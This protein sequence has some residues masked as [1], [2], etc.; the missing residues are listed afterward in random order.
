MVSRTVARW[1]STETR[2]RGKNDQ[3]FCSS[4][5][6]IPRFGL[7]LYSDAG[8]FSPDG[9]RMVLARHEF[10]RSRCATGASSSQGPDGS[11]ATTIYDGP[12]T[13]N[14]TGVAW[15]PRRDAIMFGLGGYSS[16]TAE[17]RSARLMSVRPRRYRSHEVTDGSTN[18]GMPSWSPDGTE[19]VFRVGE[20]RRSRSLDLES[21][22]LG[23]AAGLATGY[24][25]R[26]VSDLGH[27]AATGSPSRAS[28]TATTR[29]TAFAQ[30]VRAYSA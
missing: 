29:S 26:H 25:I 23:N 19:V 13:D 27:R 20:P 8:S 16:R 4:R 30:T 15:S 1:C 22:R 3:W 9:T 18:D 12:A 28:A 21:S 24:E 14:L 7:S 10:R 5:A 2:S 11:N 6:S 17:T